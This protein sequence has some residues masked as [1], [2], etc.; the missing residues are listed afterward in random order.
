MLAAVRALLALILVGGIARAQGVPSPPP[1]PTLSTGIS[2]GPPPAATAEVTRLWPATLGVHALIG[3]EPHGDRGTPAA[4]GVGAEAMWR[5]RVGGFAE[6]LSSEGT[7][8][9]AHTTGQIVNGQPQTLPS[10]GDRVS[11]PFGVVWRPFT[12][13]APSSGRWVRQFLAGMG[14]QAGITVEHVRTSDD[15]ATVAGFHAAAAV[16]VP[17]FGG[18]TAGGVTFRINGRLLATPEIRLDTKITQSVFEGS[19]NGQLFFGLCY[20]P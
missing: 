19:V 18:P 2:G 1:Q 7:P 20:Y 10:L 12:T 17:L 8:I 9:L 5:G 11:V 4:F 14:V 15:S 13:L 6:V 16:E 3:V